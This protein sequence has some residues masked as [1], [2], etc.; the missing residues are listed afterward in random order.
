ME[1]QISQNFVERCTY[2]TLMAGENVPI[3]RINKS[4]GSSKNIFQS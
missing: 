4:N 1:Q 2:E 3:G